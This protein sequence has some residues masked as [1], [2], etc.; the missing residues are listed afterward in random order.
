MAVAI[1]QP[2][3]PIPALKRRQNLIGEWSSQIKGVNWKT[4]HRYEND[5]NM[6]QE[7]VRTNSF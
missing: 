1:K 7:T 4:L 5:K 6:K 2:V 3:L